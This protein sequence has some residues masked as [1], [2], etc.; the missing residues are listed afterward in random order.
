M[1]TF[2][3]LKALLNRMFSQPRYMG[4]LGILIILVVAKVVWSV[5]FSLLIEQLADPAVHTVLS[6]VSETAGTILLIAVFYV[7]VIKPFFHAKQ[8]AHSALRLSEMKY[9]ETFDQA[10]VGVSH[11]GLDGSWL[12]VNKHLCHLLGYTAEELSGMKFQNITHPDDLGGDLAN[13]ERLKAGD[14]DAYDMEKRY[15][16][17]DGSV[18]WVNLTVSLVR[19]KDNTPDFFISVVEDNT[20]K[21]KTEKAAELL[22]RIVELS[23]NE[24]YIFDA[25]TLLFTSVNYGARQNLG[26]T[27][28]ELK[29]MTPVDIKPQHTLDK[30]TEIVAPLKSGKSEKI[31]F[32]TV[33]RRKDGTD[34]PVEVHLQLAAKEAPP[35]FVAFILDITERNTLTK[36]LNETVEKLQQ[37]SRTK[38]DFL[39]NMSHELRTP[40]NAIIGFSE[41]IGNQYLGQISQIKYIEYAQDIENSGRYL[42]ELINDILDLSKIEAGKYTLEPVELDVSEVVNSSVNL[43]RQRADD[44]GVALESIERGPQVALWADSRAVKQILI[45][46]LGNALKFTPAGG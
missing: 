46:I 30:F 43:L 4:V 27:I 2:T 10:A 20:G 22:G 5:V 35:V 17:K 29:G 3:F 7:W 39:A 16:A 41:V 34:Y 1:I 21:K 24:V 26:Y 38:S 37:A 36:E 25:K 42:L 32:N 23:L 12:L 13:V 11:V 8:A 18:V 28:E 31:I 33:H 40:L 15:I 9:R 14:I 19:K 45:N 6:A 44:K